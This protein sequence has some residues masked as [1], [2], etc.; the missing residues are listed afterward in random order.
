MVAASID[1]CT[2]LEHGNE[3][4]P[5]LRWLKVLLHLSLTFRYKM[6]NQSGGLGQ[7]VT[8]GEMGDHLD[9]GKKEIFAIS[10]EL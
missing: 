9:K 10:C 7:R 3:C 6:F 2:G 8:F 4:V 5:H 1:A